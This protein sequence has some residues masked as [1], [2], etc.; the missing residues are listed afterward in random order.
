MTVFIIFW[1][2]YLSYSQEYLWISIPFYHPFSHY[3][4]KLK[5]PKQ[6]FH[7]VTAYK[8][9]PMN[10]LSSSDMRCLMFF[11][12]LTFCSSLIALHSKSPGDMGGDSGSCLILLSDINPCT[13]KT[14]SNPKK[15]ERRKMLKFCTSSWTFKLFVR[16]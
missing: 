4:L 9:G 16:S 14:L 12:S 15:W 13:A 6:N 5:T 8:D 10:F 2:P 3:F 7:I 1:G 11:L